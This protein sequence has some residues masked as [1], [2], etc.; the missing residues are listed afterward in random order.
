MKTECIALTKL[1]S[2][3]EKPIKIK[4]EIL[5]W[6]LKFSESLSNPT[7]VGLPLHRL[8]VGHKGI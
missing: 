3:W 7:T 1:K 2:I 5:A 4:Q 8:V 6:H